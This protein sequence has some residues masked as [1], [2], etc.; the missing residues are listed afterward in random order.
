M[1]SYNLIENLFYANIK[2]Y[3]LFSLFFPDFIVCYS[4]LNTNTKIYS[5]V[6]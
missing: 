6:L 5:N 3:S 2:L 1:G 4:K